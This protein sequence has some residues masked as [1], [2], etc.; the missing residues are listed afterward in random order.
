MNNELMSEV[1]K[2]LDRKM[3]IQNRNVLL[4]LDNATSHQKSFEKRLSNIKLVFLPKNTLSSLQPLNAG[5][6]RA[7]KLTFTS[8]L[9]IILRA[10]YD[11][12]AFDIINEID[13]LKVIDWIKS[14][15]RDVILCI[16][17]C[18]ENCGFPTDD[19]VVTSQDSDEEFLMLFN[20]ISVTC[21]SDDYI[22]ANT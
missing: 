13:I 19:Y 12:R 11:K 2:R 10:D 4:F 16:K 22:E 18:F 5:I 9:L 6:I 3:K 1:L 15:W 8:K 14:T 21:S 20:E 7:F 17:N